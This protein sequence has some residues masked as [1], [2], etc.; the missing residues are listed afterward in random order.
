MLLMHAVDAHHVCSILTH[1]AV[2]MYTV[3]VQG[4][5]MYTVCVHC[6]VLML[7]LRVQWHVLM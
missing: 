2:L 4:V 6:V 7:M 5:L 1:M 3:Y